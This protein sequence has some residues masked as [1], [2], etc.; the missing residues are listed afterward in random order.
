MTMHI[1]TGNHYIELVTG[2]QLKEGDFI[3]G[4]LSR[5]GDHIETIYGTVTTKHQEPE[6]GVMLIDGTASYLWMMDDVYTVRR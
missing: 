1:I 2:A 6:N 3:I 4:K 5:G